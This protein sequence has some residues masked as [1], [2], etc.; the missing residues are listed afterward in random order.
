MFRLEFKYFKEASNVSDYY[1]KKKTTENQFIYFDMTANE[2]DSALRFLLASI[3]KTKEEHPQLVR[4]AAMDEDVNVYLAHLMFAIALPEYH[5][6]ADP[7]LSKHSSDIME[8]VKGTEDR[9]IRYFIYKV[10][11]DQCFCIR[12]CLM[13]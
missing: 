4:Q 10:N 9:T 6:M 2:R 5:E 7:Y 3:I 13:T 8:W 11:A 1:M 12:L